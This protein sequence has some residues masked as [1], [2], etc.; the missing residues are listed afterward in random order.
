MGAVAIDPKVFDAGKFCRGAKLTPANTTFPIVH[1]GCMGGTLSYS[2]LLR[3]APMRSALFAFGVELQA[4]ASTPD[5][6]VPLDQGGKVLPCGCAE[7]LDGEARHQSMCLVM[8]VNV[9]GQRR[10]CVNISL[11]HSV[12]DGGIGQFNRNSGHLRVEPHAQRPRYL[13]DG[14]E[15]RVAVLTERLVQA[16]PT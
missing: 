10:T 8:P 12:G 4:P 9:A 16:L 11:W 14:C 6:V 15:T 2:S 5:T 7:S 3:L 1:K 13:Q